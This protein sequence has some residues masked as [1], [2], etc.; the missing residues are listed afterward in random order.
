MDYLLTEEQKMMRDMVS[1]FA[2]EEIGP[3]AREFQE[4]GIYPEEVVKKCS[5]LGLMGIA[6]PAEYGGAGMDFVSYMLAVEEISRY[7]AST[8]VIISAHSSLAVDPI[9]RFGNEEQKKKYMPD[10]CSGKRIGCYALTEPGSGS[11]AGAAKTTAKLEGDKW[12]INGTKHFITNGEE[13]EVTVVFALT[14][15]EKKTRGLSAFIVEKGTPGF[16]V[17]K[18]EHKLGINST[19]TTELI[20]EDC[21]VPKEN[22]LGE[23]NKGF[24]VAMITLD[25]GRLGIAAQALGIARASIEDSIKFAKEREQFDQPIAN[26]Q[27]IQ[28]MLADMWTEYE[29]AWLLTYRASLMK[30]RNL[31]YSLEAA[32]A[33]L[34]A[35][36]VASFCAAKAVQIHGGYGYT[37]EFDV[38]RYLRDAKITE[39]YEGTNE[40]MRVVISANLLK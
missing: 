8:G 2:K 7:C 12:I 25:G 22:L 29:A 17:G 31:P 10:M 34:K 9:F 32:T 26:F 14:E 28:W 27:G 20:F 1:K 4:K 33:K 37:K 23:F 16:T 11:D 24:K 19:S 3:V 40:I 38:E 39:I 18:H 13:A 21:A 36:E 35:S 30:D 15:P 5:E 6:Y